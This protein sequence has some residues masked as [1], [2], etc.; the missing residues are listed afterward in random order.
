M[1]N[2]ILSVLGMVEN[3]DKKCF[4]HNDNFYHYDKFTIKILLNK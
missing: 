2:Y 1:I 4:Y 3:S